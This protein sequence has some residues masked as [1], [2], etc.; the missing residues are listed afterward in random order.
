MIRLRTYSVNTVKSVQL[1][2]VFIPQ[3]LP[4]V[5]AYPNIAC[6]RLTWLLH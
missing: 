6:S 3:R 5:E 1:S 4:V 2:I